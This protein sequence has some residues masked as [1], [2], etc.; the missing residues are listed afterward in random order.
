MRYDYYHAAVVSDDQDTFEFVSIGP[1][2]RILKKVVFD[3]TSHPDIFNLAFGDVPTNGTM[4]TDKAITGNE[5]RNK[6]LATI[7]KIVNVYTSAHPQ[8][9]V[10]IRGSTPSRTRLYKMAIGSNFKELNKMYVIYG[11]NKDGELEP[12]SSEKQF[13]AFLVKKKN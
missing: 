7:A 9:W 2:G 3:T 10:H 5:D 8:R 11:Y 12:F 6:T 13:Q 4:V 1:R